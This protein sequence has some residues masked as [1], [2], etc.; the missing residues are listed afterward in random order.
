MSNTK[1]PDNLNRRG[2]TPQPSKPTTA[3]NTDRTA[4]YTPPPIQDISKPPKK[5]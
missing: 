4:G 2:Y 1:N 3:N 5:I